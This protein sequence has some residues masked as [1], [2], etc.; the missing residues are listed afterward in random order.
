MKRKPANTAEAAVKAAVDAA[1]GPPECPPHVRLREED[2]PFWDGVVRARTRDE[3][4]SAD[5]VVAGQLARCQYD[6]ERESLALDVEGT[7]VKNDRGT[8]VCNPRVTVLEQLARREMALM[9]TLR[10]GGA[11]AGEARHVLERR[12]VAKQ[13]ENVRAE[14]EEDELLA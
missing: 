3:W 7:V 13:A 11:A 2:L 12:R 10:L 5:L 14:L 8:Q 6:I 1:K 9:R 4:T